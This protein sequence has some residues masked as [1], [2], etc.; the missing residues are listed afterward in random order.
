[1]LFKMISQT[2]ITL[3]NKPNPNINNIKG[4]ICL[5]YDIIFV[6]L[7]FIKKG[8]VFF[9]VAPAFSFKFG[10]FEADHKLVACRF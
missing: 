1:M 6:K 4:I 3:K 9:D 10:L 7:F 2:L 8:N 5:S